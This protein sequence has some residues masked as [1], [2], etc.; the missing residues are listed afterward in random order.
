MCAY[1]LRNI[2]SDLWVKFRA[3]TKAEGDSARVVII[4]L[5]QRYLNGD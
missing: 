3:K 4:R 1:L 2:P 5:I